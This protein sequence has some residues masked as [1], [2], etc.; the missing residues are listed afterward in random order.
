MSGEKILVVEDER[1]IQ[2]LVRFNLAK[3]GYSVFCTI[4]GEDALA[5]VRSEPP[6]LVL[7][8]LMLPGLDGLEVCKRLT[9]D[10]ATRDVPIIMLTA[11]GEEADIVTGLELGA[12]DY[13][14]KPF[15]P[16]VLIA[17]NFLG[18]CRVSDSFVFFKTSLGA[19]GTVISP[20]RFAFLRSSRSKLFS[21]FNSSAFRATPSAP[22]EVLCGGTIRSG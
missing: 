6:D 1:E 21:L 19:L 4:S 10:P 16:R 9:N 11:R 17:R 8:D 2:E 13:I 15:S 3:V 7:L 18:D 20:R 14:T 12:D 22:I 5:E